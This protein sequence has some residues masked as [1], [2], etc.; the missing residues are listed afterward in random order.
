LD[1]ALAQIQMRK[2][3]AS[4]QPPNVGRRYVEGESEDDEDSD[5]EEDDDDVEIEHGNEA[6]EIEEVRMASGRQSRDTDDEASD[7][8]VGKV[9]ASASKKSRSK[10]KGKANG[11]VDVV[12]DAAGGFSE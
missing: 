1:L 4:A 12:M 6:G 7:A 2:A 5:E 10:G 8:E 3:L 11:D 9:P